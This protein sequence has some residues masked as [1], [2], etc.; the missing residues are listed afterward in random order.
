MK[1]ALAFTA[2]LLAAL[3]FWWFASNDASTPVAAAP[4]HTLTDA[5]GRGAVELQ[6]PLENETAPT[7]AAETAALESARAEITE[8]AAP[9]PALAEHPEFAR[10]DLRVVSRD[11]G[12]P[13]PNHRVTLFPRG[14][15]A[16]NGQPGR[17]NVALPGESACTN[18]RG[19]AIL[20]A[21]PGVGVFSLSESD[22][23]DAQ[24]EGSELV[25]VQTSD[26]GDVIRFGVGVEAPTKTARRA[27][28]PQIVSLDAF[29]A[30]HRV[31]L[32][33]FGA[34]ERRSVTLA[35]RVDPD[36][37]V[38]GLVLDAWT[39]APLA[40]AVV[41]LDG[42]KRALSDENG[43][44]FVA[45]CSWEH[46]QFDVDLDGYLSAEAPLEP[47]NEAPTNRRI[48]LLAPSV[49]L[50]VS[51]VDAHGQ[52][53][54]AQV[55]ANL[56][57]ETLPGVVEPM[58]WKTWSMPASPQRHADLFDLPAGV[59]IELHARTT[60]GLEVTRKLR[61]TPGE[62]PN[63]VVLQLPEAAAISG[64]L[65]GFEPL[66]GREVRIRKWNGPDE[67]ATLDS[68]SNDRSTWSLSSRSSWARGP[69]D[70][71]TRT[72]AHGRFEFE[73]VGPGR[74]QVS[75]ADDTQRT[76]GAS[77][78]VDVIDREPHEVVLTAQPAAWIRG[79]VTAPSGEALDAL[80]SATSFDGTLSA[81]GD[82][83]A[84]GEFTF[85]PVPPG[86]Y[87]VRARGTAEALRQPPRYVAALDVEL[88]AG[89]NKVELRCY[90][91]RWL[92]F[93]LDDS[94]HANMSGAI[95]VV[96]RDG[97]TLDLPRWS[98]F[99]GHVALDISNV[100]EP[101]TL[102]ARSSDGRFAGE[103]AFDPT[104]WTSELQAW[105]LEPVAPPDKR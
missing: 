16:W 17:G 40:G 88:V 104:L 83:R 69:R 9:E 14:T 59:Q 15:T 81:V 47:G 84:A 66:A 37:L 42:E 1:L 57:S 50:E 80:L 70:N 48:V 18:A 92:Q 30:D 94:S 35:V 67:W 24:R 10:F 49:D 98:G 43:A 95:E 72:D 31:A 87:R 55:S 71:M 36:R 60:R 86:A 56:T 64:A 85:G 12:K 22:D 38:H 78:Q 82:T 45:A 13:V 51:V 65:A 32:E 20:F 5:E 11:T 46:K 97:R 23:A 91:A 74:W 73:D 8:S 63:L 21:E 7:D 93:F 33:P 68:F 96:S 41:R 29:H 58:R 19:E 6:R 52:R 79:T 90:E 61:A 76:A 89:S 75:C 103:R 100:R 54:S 25:R 2:A 39:R 44:F 4:T 62:R 34:G 77:A 101:V 105:R 28:T 27:G 3:V 99:G 53:V 102:R 26:S